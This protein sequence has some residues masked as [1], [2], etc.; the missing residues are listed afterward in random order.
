MNT[1]DWVLLIIVLSCALR[2]IWRGAIAQVLSI[3]GL[4][5]GFVL[6]SHFYLP[7]SEKLKQTFPALGAAHAIGFAVLFVLTWLCLAVCGA[8]LA[9]LFRKTG[10]GFVDRIWGLLLGLCKAIVAS[11][12]LI[13][14]LTFVLPHESPVLRQ[15]RLIPY[16]YET[17]RVMVEMTPKRVRD[18]FEL[19][20]Q[21]IME[22]WRDRENP[23]IPGGPKKPTRKEA[24]LPS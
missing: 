13:A 7:L 19:K 10:L 17:S 21:K 6:A 22:Y 12:I 23:T 9:R 4:V 5:G 11:I 3:I 18:L 20:R 1:L 14:A 16:V 24:L 2:G 8:W 15:S